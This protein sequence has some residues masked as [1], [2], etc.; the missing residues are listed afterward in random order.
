M[1]KKVNKAIKSAV[2]EVEVIRCKVAKYEYKVLNEVK[3]FLSNAGISS[4]VVS[5]TRIKNGD[6]IYVNGLQVNDSKAQPLMYLAGTD[7]RT[8]RYPQGTMERL[9]LDFL[10]RFTDNKLDSIG[11]CFDI[12][13]DGTTKAVLWNFRNYFLSEKREFNEVN[14]MKIYNELKTY[15]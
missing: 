1:V 8:V 11:L 9:R 10:M 5:V 7:L 6:T 13:Q 3:R 14:F 2:S 12:L 4:E 15:C